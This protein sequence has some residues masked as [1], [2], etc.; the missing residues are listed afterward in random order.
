MLR[1]RQTEVLK[2]TGKVLA[3]PLKPEPHLEMARYDRKVGDYS[4]AVSEYEIAADLWRY[5]GTQ[6][7]GSGEGIAA[8]D[9]LKRVEKKRAV[10]SVASSS[11]RSRF[12]PV[13]PTRTD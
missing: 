1:T 6:A 13:K 3:D 10:I 7:T 4:R 2:L 8:M 9:H 12:G 5:E 11:E